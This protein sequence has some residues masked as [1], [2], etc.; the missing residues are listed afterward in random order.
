MPI[1]F[2]RTQKS[3]V[4][5]RSPVTVHEEWHSLALNGRRNGRG[6]GDRVASSVTKVNGKTKQ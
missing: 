4:F 5:N 1:G 2:D 3:A 6:F